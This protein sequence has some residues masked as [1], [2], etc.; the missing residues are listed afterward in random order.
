M[1]QWKVTNP[2]P[3]GTPAWGYWY[4]GF[5]SGCVNPVLFGAIW[6]VVGCAFGA[7]AMLF[8]VGR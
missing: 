3:V 1:F 5:I 2:H 6:F 7:A 4:H 8:G